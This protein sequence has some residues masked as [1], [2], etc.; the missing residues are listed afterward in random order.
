MTNNQQ[1]LTQINQLKQRLA[2]NDQR[3]FDDLQLYLSTAGLFYNETQLNQQL[4]NML[5]DLRDANADGQ[6]AIDFFGND[7]QTMSN[8]IIKQLPTPKLRDQLSFISIIIG[9]T[10]LFQLLYSRN[11]AAG[12]HLNIIA[13]VIVPIIEVLAIMLIFRVLHHSVYV[14]PN[15][16][17]LGYVQTALIFSVTVGLMLAFTNLIPLGWTLL[18]PSPWNNLLLTLIAII[19]TGTLV[20]VLSRYQHRKKR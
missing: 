9:I 13:L 20:F 3:Y 17:W 8:E 12:M 6:S 14:A 7:P 18:I 4:L 1:T 5:L 11:T 15:R 2:A 16:K 10:W 19:A